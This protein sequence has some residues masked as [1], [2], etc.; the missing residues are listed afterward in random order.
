MKPDIKNY[1]RCFRIKKNYKRGAKIYSKLIKKDI[2][3]I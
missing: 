1:K 2:L 3:S